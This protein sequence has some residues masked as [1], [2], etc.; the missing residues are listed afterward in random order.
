MKDRRKK[1]L[2]KA[3]AFLCVVLITVVMLFR[4][5]R[6]EK[7]INAATAISEEIYVGDK[8]YTKDN[9]LDILEIVPDESLAEL[10]Y[11]I[12]EEQSPVKWSDIMK[13]DSSSDR[14]K[15]AKE[16]IQHLSSLMGGNKVQIGIYSG[17]TCK[18]YTYASAEYWNL[19][20]SDFKKNSLVRIVN[21]SG[22]PYI[23][24]YNNEYNEITTNNMWAYYVFGGYDMCDKVQLKTKTAAKVTREDVKSADLIYINSG[25]HKDTYVKIYKM[26]AELSNEYVIDTDIS[27][28][29]QS[30]N[31][32]SRLS[33]DLNVSVM[34]D[35]YKAVANEEVALMVDNNLRSNS[36]KFS[37]I[38]KLY[39]M[40]MA[41][42]KED[43]KTHFWNVTYSDSLYT[44]TVGSVIIDES[45]N[46]FDITYVKKGVE[47][48]MEWTD[49]G[50]IYYMMLNNFGG[51]ADS[52]FN[53]GT[54]D[55]IVNKNVYNYNGN[56]ALDMQFLSG[57]INYKGPREGTTLEHA[58]ELFGTT[59]QYGNKVIS[60]PNAIL[61]ILG[62]Y[63]LIKNYQDVLEVL[64][65]EPAGSYKYSEDKLNVTKVRR[66]F[67]YFKYSVKGLNSE[68]FL[69]YVNVTSV[70]MNAFIGM[71]DD[72]QSKYDLIIISDYNTDD[73]NG[74]NFINTDITKIYTNQGPQ[75]TLS[76][77]EK[78]D[79]V[80]KRTNK[81]VTLSGNDITLKMYQKIVDYLHAG[82]PLILA[83]SI[84][85]GDENT[86]DK[87]SNLYKLSKENLVNVLGE[88]G[89]K[90]VTCESNNEKKILI[91]NERPS[92]T[93]DDE[94]KYKDVNNDKIADVN[95]YPS[96][97]MTIIFKGTINK[98]L[99]HRYALSIFIDKD[100]NG[101]YVQT[102][103]DNNELIY[104]TKNLLPD[105]NGRFSITLPKF[106][107]NT[108]GYY[109]WKVV[110]TDMETNMRAEET[111]A[112]VIGYDEGT[113][114]E[115]RALQIIPGTGKETLMLNSKEFTECFR[116]TGSVTGYKLNVKVMTVEEFVNMYKLK[117]FKKVTDTYG[118]SNVTNDLLSKSEDKGYDIIILGFQDS[119]G[120]KD[121]DNTNGAMDNINY[122]IER[123]NA[124]LMSHDVLSYSS[125]SDKD[126]KNV[127]V[128]LSGEYLSYEIT[129]SLRDV[130]GMDRFNATNDCEISFC[131]GYTNIFIQQWGTFQGGKCNLYNNMEPIG[132]QNVYSTEVD[133]LNEGQITQYPYEISE[134]IDVAKTHEQYFQLDLESQ[135]QNESD[136]IMV[137][138]T[139]GSNS[140]RSFY[141]M[142]GM[143]ALNNYYIYS[144]ANIT[145]SGAGH[146]EITNSKD[147]LRLF[148]NTIIRAIDSG[149]SAPGVVFENPA[150]KMDETNYEQL[151]REENIEEIS[152]M[153]YD[154]DMAVQGMFS[155]G[156][157]FWD[158]NENGAYEETDE[159]LL[160]YSKNTGEYLVNGKIETVNLIRDSFGING[161]FTEDDRQKMIE[162][163]KNNNCKIAVSVK[164]SRNI[165]G[166]AILNI[167]NRE[168]FQLD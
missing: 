17:N 59:D 101:Y 67:N 107:Q 32:F 30:N 122:Y 102:T 129:K 90:N 76:Y 79:G 41:A 151:I 113:E 43:F 162:S 99:S 135:G 42:D 38:Q 48:R 16:W 123:G 2:K 24:T 125:Y 60:T 19:K 148:V 33:Q 103:D 37:N 146:S 104:E 80:E 157:L 120:K 45:E 29:G 167:I 142:S 75:L 91:H 111:D 130:V 63:K 164:D 57:N 139:L 40:V 78:K 28:A 98:N 73:I 127:M 147:E 7:V 144:K 161:S 77:I 6:I 94:L 53:A 109:R 31:N 44:G 71:A 10:G 138:Y 160:E 156:C 61:Y 36:S 74:G 145:Y 159:L 8:V 13:L 150:V 22:N 152:F 166:Y 97:S 68:N 131:Q 50:C 118:V 25:Y 134:C 70:S 39:T 106:A 3:T 136:D 158:K 9:K 89:I 116:E 23:Y 140:L 133:R 86:V 72:I 12:G 143:D 14:M 27:L 87:K 100:A 88:N 112:F 46:I 64:E 51:Y 92:F 49:F 26:M 114:K 21:E 66:L 47:T 85:E 4:F 168:L 82:K 124:V 65:V 96:E 81:L 105:A 163:I 121:I 20:K 15:L 52:Y 115:I 141:K 62:D 1:T 108:R 18:W 69:D 95:I 149:N 153:A 119:Y 137:W 11:M 5:N 154:T 93:I 165:T 117:P 128:R 56:N 84:Y 126:M 35:I 34:W 55:N 58:Y 110:L 155:Y 54:F 83:D 132:S